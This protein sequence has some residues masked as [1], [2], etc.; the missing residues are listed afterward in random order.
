MKFPTFACK[1]KLLPSDATKRDLLPI[2]SQTL[3]LCNRPL[4]HSTLN[5]YSHKQKPI[6]KG[7][8]AQDPTS[9]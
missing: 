3:A 2:S 9:L 8:Y 1:R 5:S 4:K 7:T 6:F